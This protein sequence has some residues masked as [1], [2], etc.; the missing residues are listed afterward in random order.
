MG[1]NGMLSGHSLSGIRERYS[2][3]T[4]NNLLGSVYES[5]KLCCV[6]FSCKT[7]LNL[8]SKL[9]V[10][11]LNS[12]PEDRKVESENTKLSPLCATL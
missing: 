10:K 12:F 11:P 7:A 5:S 2:V 3:I 4:T 1:S 6:H 8:A 9:T